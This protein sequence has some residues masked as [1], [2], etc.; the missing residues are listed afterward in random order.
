MQVFKWIIVVI[1]I[2][3]AWLW[4][5]SSAE[6]IKV[7]VITVDLGVVEATVA[8][9]RSGTIKACKRS[10]LA[11]AQGG[12]ISAIYVQEGEQVKTGQLLLELWNVNVKAQVNRAEAAWQS[13][14]LQTHSICIAAA[15][16][17][18]EAKRFSELAKKELTSKELVDRALAKADASEATCLAAKA[19]E[20]EFIAQLNL[21]KSLLEQTYLYAPFD[22]I[23][24]EV[25]GEVGEIAT[26]SPPGVATPPAIDLLTNNCFYLSAPIDEVDAALVRVGQPAKITLDA[27]RGIAFSGQVSRIAPYVE[28]FA[29]Q[30]RTVTIEAEFD[31]K[32]TQMLAGYSADIEVILNR[33]ESVLRIPTETIIESQF[34]WKIVHGQLQKTKV[35]TGVSNWQYTEIIS[36]LSAGDKIVSSLGQNGLAEGVEVIEFDQVAL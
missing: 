19:Q 25:T 18:R 7:E 20:K 29:K 28:D 10:K 3:V 30:A 36:G 31:L 21:Q 2:V 17:E 15:S 32:E 6:V 22:G 1:V 33:K 27:F 8:N 35:E 13:H 26:P 5:N 11:P 4:F 34:V 23:I 14:R 9:T 24:A 16:D 12:Q